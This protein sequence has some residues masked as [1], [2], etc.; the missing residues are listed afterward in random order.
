MKHFYCYWYRAKFV[1][2]IQVFLLV[3]IPALSLIGLAL[4]AAPD[5]LPADIEA[6]RSLHLRLVRLAWTLVT[7][8]YFLKL[9]EEDEP[10]ELSNWLT[11][12]FYPLLASLVHF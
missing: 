6:L 2:F 11:S 9:F 3:Q 5:S 8:H 10:L 12:C 4:L 7:F 1:R